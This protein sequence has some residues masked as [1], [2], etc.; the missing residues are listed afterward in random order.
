MHTHSVH[1]QGYTCDI[2]A[3]DLDTFAAPTFDNMLK[4]WYDALWQMSRPVRR[5]FHPRQSHIVPRLGWPSATRA[6]SRWMGLAS[7]ANI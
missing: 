5:A 3:N 2:R 7:R 6:D 1:A 4:E